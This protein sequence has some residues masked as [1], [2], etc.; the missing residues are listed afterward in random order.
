MNIIKNIKRTKEHKLDEKD[1]ARARVCAI[2]VPIHLI[3][4]KVNTG[5]HKMFKRV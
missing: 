1:A 4:D 3:Y 2:Y 5:C